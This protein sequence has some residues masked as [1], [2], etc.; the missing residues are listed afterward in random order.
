MSDLLG[1]L[2]ELG[3]LENAQGAKKGHKGKTVTVTKAVAGTV[4]AGGKNGTSTITVT[5]AA[6]VA[7]GTGYEKSNT[8]DLTSTN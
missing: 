5:Q 3:A 2:E 6:G 7:A 8:E 1:E 4:A